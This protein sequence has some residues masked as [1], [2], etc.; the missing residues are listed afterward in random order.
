MFSFGSAAHA[1]RCKVHPR[2][3]FPGRY[4]PVMTILRRILLC[5]MMAVWPAVARAQGPDVRGIV[6]DSAS[7]EPIPGVVVMMVDERGQIV[8]RTISGARGQYR[9]LRPTSEVQLRAIRLGFRPTSLRLPLPFAEST[10]INLSMA[11]VARTL[12]AVNVVAARG[13]PSRADRAEAFGL[14]DQAR[15]GLLATVVARERQI[16][17]MRVLRYERW[18]D[19]DGVSI[20]RQTVQIDSSVR[21][22]TSFNAVQSAVDFV[23][24]GFR[25]GR[26]G[27]YTYFGPDA[28]ILLDE[29]FQR[30]YCFRLA[31]PQ[32]GRET[33]RGLQ[34]SPASRRRGR[35]DIE[36]T[37]W[38]DTAQRT[39][40]DVDFL[41]VGVD[42]IAA[43]FGTGGRIQFHTLPNGITFID[44]WS[45][46]LVGAADTIETDIGTSSQEYAIREVGGEVALAR[47]TDSTTFDAPPF[48]CA[49]YGR[50]VQWGASRVDADASCGHRLQHRDRRPGPQCHPVLA[51]RSVPD[52][53]E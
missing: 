42:R 18:L 8:N 41:Y 28:D 17:A 47:W 48:Q 32:R 50:A 24:K 5:T 16:A 13:C 46:R 22:A 44:Q 53:G 12:D 45:L 7:G 20:E 10:V 1:P 21:A 33:Q 35:V 51:A 3:S 39:L 11:T 19:I 40:R 2:S 4:L 36:G 23:E 34:F 15:A 25:A 27:R 6:R 43:S 52:A 26:D 38:I 14:L 31:D 9:V 30:G 29:R 37:L 49:H